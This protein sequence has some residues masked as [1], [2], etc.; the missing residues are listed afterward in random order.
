M[1]EVE[2]INR[3]GKMLPMPEKQISNSKVPGCTRVK[4]ENSMTMNTFDNRSIVSL[5]SARSKLDAVLLGQ[6]QEAQDSVV[7]FGYNIFS[8]HK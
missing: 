8:K 5:E 2:G 4:A 1:M 6:M 7:Q 3:T